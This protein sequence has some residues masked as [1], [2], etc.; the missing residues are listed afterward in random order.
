MLQQQKACSFQIFNKILRN[1][2]NPRTNRL[3]P[4]IFSG[5]KMANV[6][7]Q[8][9]LLTGGRGG[10]KTGKNETGKEKHYREGF[11]LSI[12]LMPKII[13]L[14]IADAKT[15]HIIYL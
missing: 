10:V 7:V 13:A 15:R 3:T 5:E 9:R 2:R 6:R 8:V 12:N 1:N 11:H 14:V 4:G